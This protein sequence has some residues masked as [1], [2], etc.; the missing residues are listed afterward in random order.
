[1]NADNISNRTG[2]VGAIAT[3]QGLMRRSA[4]G[5]SYNVEVSLTQFNNWYLRQV[6]LHSQGT[7]GSLRKLHPDFQPRHD[8]DIF[9]LITATIAAMK[10]LGEKD[11]GHLW[12][13]AK[14]TSGPTRWSKEGETATYLDW[15]RI[16]TVKNDKGQP[17]VVFDFDHGSCL[18]GSDLAEW[19]S[20]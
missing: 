3:M 6:G 2:L 5:G 8:M 15:R 18:P 1:M 10:A 12:D 17:L 19:L 4:E 11:V 13:P 7:Q 9:E 14:F 20:D 16:V